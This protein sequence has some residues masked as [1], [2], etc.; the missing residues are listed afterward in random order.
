MFIDEFIIHEVNLAPMRFERDAG[1]HEIIPQAV[2]VH[3]DRLFLGRSLGDVGEIHEIEFD[4]VIQARPV[5][6][7]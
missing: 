2:Q 3:V 1:L 5:P 7:R 6:G 4:D